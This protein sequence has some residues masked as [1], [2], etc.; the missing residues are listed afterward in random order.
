MGQDNSQASLPAVLIAF[1]AATAC[2]VSA[3]VA[4]ACALVRSQAL[5]AYCLPVC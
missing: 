1:F 2:A 4:T 3:R 5:P